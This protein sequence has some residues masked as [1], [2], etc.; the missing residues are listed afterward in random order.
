[1]RAVQKSMGRIGDT[2]RD[3]HIEVRVSHGHFDTRPIKKKRWLC[4][5]AARAML[6]QL[7]VQ[8]K[9]RRRLIFEA[10]RL[11]MHPSNAGPAQSTLRAARQ[12]FPAVRLHHVGR[13]IRT[14][15]PGIR[16]G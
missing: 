13:L 10:E 6:P 12:R 14:E 1:M 15:S 4:G 3:N 2:Q 16:V 5:S 7:Y 8:F 9:T 11:L